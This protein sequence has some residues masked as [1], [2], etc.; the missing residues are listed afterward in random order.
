MLAWLPWTNDTSRQSSRDIWREWPNR[1]SNEK[2][3]LS[4]HQGKKVLTKL[5][6]PWVSSHCR[7]TFNFLNYILIFYCLALTPLYFNCLIIVLQLIP[8]WK[9][10]YVLLFLNLIYNVFH[11]VFVPLKYILSSHY[12]LPLS[13]FLFSLGFTIRILILRPLKKNPV[14]YISIF[15]I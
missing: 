13:A 10:I 15:L 1:Q 14:N 11:N 7:F 5:I 4:S 9:G 3:K 6:T 8:H 2:E 12:F